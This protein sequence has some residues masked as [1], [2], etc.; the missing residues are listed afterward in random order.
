MNKYQEA[1]DFATGPVPRRARLAFIRN[2]IFY[3]D[4]GIDPQTAKARA[5]QDAKAKCGNPIIWWLVAYILEQ[6]VLP[7]LLEWWERRRNR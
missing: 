2:W 5:L 1:F 4:L 3:R 7:K 6:I